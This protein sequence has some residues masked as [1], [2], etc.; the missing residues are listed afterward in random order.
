MKY[1]FSGFKMSSK[2]S[3]LKEDYVC[4]HV[5]VCNERTT[6]ILNPKMVTL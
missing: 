5:V 6:R 2:K 4:N 1:E 3:M